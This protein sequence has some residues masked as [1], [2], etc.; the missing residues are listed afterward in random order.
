MQGRPRY[1]WLLCYWCTPKLLDSFKL[2]VSLKLLDRNILALSFLSF[3]KFI[4]HD[5][6]FN[7]YSGIQQI[8]FGGRRMGDWEEGMTNPEYGYKYFKI[9]FM[10]DY[11]LNGP[12][13]MYIL[14]PWLEHIGK[15]SWF[16]KVDFDCKSIAD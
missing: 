16:W 1:L 3:N 7:R 2:R 10:C 5:L 4:D 12:C 14:T 11:C 9:W 13:F 8:V 6:H 15:K